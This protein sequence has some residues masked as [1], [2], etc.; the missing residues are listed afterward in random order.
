M[1]VAHSSSSTGNL[2]RR[3]RPGAP[4]RPVLRATTSSIS[5][6]SVS[7]RSR[8]AADAADEVHQPPE[9]LLGVAVERRGLRGQQVVERAVV[10]LAV[11][12]RAQDLA[13]HQ[14]CVSRWTRVASMAAAAWR[15]SRASRSM[16]LSVN[17]SPDRL[18]ST[19]STPTVPPWP[20]MG[21]AAMAYGT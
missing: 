17:V 7:S 18:S 20:T 3:V 6:T 13:Q 10:D 16:S 1:L 12:D 19:W 8:H 11:R 15:A 9:R 4:G 5:T 2:R 21:T 14:R